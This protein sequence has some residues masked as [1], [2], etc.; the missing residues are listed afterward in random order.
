MVMVKVYHG[1]FVF[2]SLIQTKQNRKEKRKQKG[3][4]Q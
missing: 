3:E 1:I 2:G 4:T